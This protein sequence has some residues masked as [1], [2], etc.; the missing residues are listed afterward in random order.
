LSD[1][2]AILDDIRLL[3]SDAGRI[4]AKGR[5]SFLDPVD[6]TSRLAAKAIVIDLQSAVERLPPAF[7]AE[8]PEVPWRDIRGMRN[9]LAHDYLGTDYVILWN[10]LV[11]DLPRIL[12]TVE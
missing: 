5:E 4:V 7:T 6:R 3:A 1:E 10:T 11:V 8:R 12:R 2:V 9:Y